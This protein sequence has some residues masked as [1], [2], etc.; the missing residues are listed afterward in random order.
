[1]KILLILFIS[2]FFLGCSEKQE[3]LTETIVKKEFVYV[4]KCDFILNSE[5]LKTNTIKIPI[6]KDN[7]E[8]ELKK[9]KEYILNLSNENLILKDKIKIIE[10]IYLN[11]EKCLK[12]S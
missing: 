9:V 3:I 5:I 2:L 7:S 6:L 10:L 1:M 12:N 8:E 4:N 11:Y